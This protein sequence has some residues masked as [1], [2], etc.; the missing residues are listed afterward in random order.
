M[1]VWLKCFNLNIN[2]FPLSI[3]LELSDG[4]KVNAEGALQPN[5]NP[6]EPAFIAAKGSY[7]YQSP[8][9]ETIHVDWT[10]DETGFHAEVSILS[11]W[12]HLIQFTNHNDHPNKWLFFFFFNYPGKTLASCLNFEK[13]MFRNWKQSIQL[14]SLYYI[15]MDSFLIKSLKKKNKKKFF[16]QEKHKI[17]F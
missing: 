6:E 4:S 14:T 17:I 16:L 3:S 8:E 5:P 2:I 10:A 13:G 7:E 1:I 11:E 12:F 9:G 15:E